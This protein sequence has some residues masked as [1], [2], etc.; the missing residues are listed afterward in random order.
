MS[1]DEYLERVRALDPAVHH[2][3]IMRIMAGHE[4]PWDFHR[5]LVDMVFLRSLAAPR[6]AG[7]IAAQGY[8]EAATQKRYDD[9]AIM[10]IELVRNGY[11][12]ERGAR[13]IERMNRIHGRFKI[14]ND[15]YLYVL[16]AL[17]IEPIRWNERFGWRLMCE[18]ER[19]S[20]Y[21]FWREVGRRMGIEGIPES[22]DECERFRRDFERQH[23]R[24]AEVTVRLGAL[25]FRLLESWLP[26]VVRPA[27]RPAMAAL[28]DDVLL[29]C[30]DIPRPPEWLRA[31]V[32]GALRVRAR[33]LRFAPPRRRP[34]TFVDNP[35]RSYPRGYAIEDL[36]PPESWDA[37]RRP[38]AYSATFPG[39]AGRTRTAL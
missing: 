12:G 11:D 33:A 35:I 13:M 26:P 28:L 22:L 34:A 37:R 6:L 27:V 32:T 5:S 10:M 24:R 30:F 16:T 3:E 15:D 36:G 19:L 14:R 7:L 21:Y 23:F 4:F 31:A 17:M 39:A 1:R 18:S 38:L 20:C 8:L 9:T 25:V 2:R 29:E